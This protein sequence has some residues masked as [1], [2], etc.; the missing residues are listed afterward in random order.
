MAAASLVLTAVLT[1]CS[2]PMP[3][4]AQLG[5]QI[6]DTFRHAAAAEPAVAGAHWWADFGDTELTHLIQQALDKNQNVLMALERV[7]AAQSGVTVQSSFMLPSVDAHVGAQRSS[8]GLPD[9]VKAAGQPD[10]RSFQG[11]LQ[12]AWEVDLSGALRAA[13]DAAT[14]DLASAEAGVVGSRLEVAAEVARQ[15]FIYRSAEKRLAVLEQLVQSKR[16]SAK[17]VAARVEQG[18]SSS[19]ELDLANA[20]ADALEAQIPALRTALVGAQ[21]AVATLLGSN[22]SESPISKRADYVWPKVLPIGAGQPSDLLRRRPDLIAVEA[23]Y[24]AETL[25]AVQARDQMWPRLFLG[26]LVGREDLRLNGTDIAP[27]NFRNVA[28][29]FAM[30][31]F[32]SGR[33][34][35]IADGRDAIARQTLL[36]WQHTALVAIQE[37]ETSLAAKNGEDARSLS[38]ASELSRRQSAFKRVQSLFREGQVN[39]LTVQEVQRAV[40]AGELD[41]VDS[42]EKRLLSYVQLFKAL[43]GGWSREAHDGAKTVAVSMNAESQ[44]NPK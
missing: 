40:L 2:T 44:R 4:K 10:V 14:S 20:D 24:S 26:A 43:G 11:S 37:V 15:Y 36:E 19:F 18:E 7:K 3:P 38:V 12:L 30:P 17:V 25:R 32:N 28:L 21:A 16:Q 8:S 9:A 35:A 23:R 6:S 27:V 22:P 42:S 34:S 13:R 31:I 33:I 39:Q 1:A 29:S 5:V 41:A